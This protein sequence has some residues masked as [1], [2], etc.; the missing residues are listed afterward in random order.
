MM[1]LKNSWLAYHKKRM[2]KSRRFL[3]IN[4]ICK[5]KKN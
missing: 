3:Q 1:K 2:L 4:I 5:R